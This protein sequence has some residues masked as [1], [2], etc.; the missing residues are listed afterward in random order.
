MSPETFG[1]YELLELLGRGGMG[2]VHRAWDTRRERVVAL[3][4][5]L[6][7]L[8]D[9]EQFR[10]RFYRECNGAAR[11]NE[12]H[13]VPIHDFGEIEGRLYLDMRLVD[14]R[15]LSELLEQ[16]GPFPADLAVTVVEQVA[17]ALDAAHA[18]GIIHRDVKP[19][20]VLVT[21]T[22]SVPHCYLV[23]F[24]IAGT[25]GGRTTGSLTRT[26]MFVGTLEYVA[27]ERLGNGPTDH[28]VDVYS[29]ACLL[30]QLLTG[31]P[32]FPTFDP[33]ALCAAH[34]YREPPRPSATVPSLP[35]ALDAVVARGM[36]KDPDARFPSAGA[37]AWAARAAL[38]GDDVRT[39][40]VPLR[41]APPTVTPPPLTPPAPATTG[42]HGAPASTPPV[43]AVTAAARSEGALPPTVTGTAPPSRD[44][45]PDPRQ[46]VGRRPARRRLAGALIAVAVAAAAAGGVVAARVLDG[47]STPV[48]TEAAD[49]PGDSPFHRPPGGG[50]QMGEQVPAP[51]QSS[52][53]TE[54]VSGDQPGLYGGT[55][56][57]VCDAAGL[58]RF[59]E[60]NPS[61]AAAWAEVQGI[62]PEGIGAFIADLTPVVL[63]FDT[64]VTNHGFV[65]GRATP[66][67]SVLQAGT[68]VLVDE[69]GSP[70]VR[71]ACGNPLDPPAPRPSPEYEGEPWP[72]FSE[73]VVVNVTPAPVVVN[74]LVV[75]YADG[76]IRERPLS[77]SGEEDKTPP[78]EVLMDAEEFVEDPTTATPPA[79]APASQSSPSTSPPASA[80]ASQ[81]SP[82]T[83][84]PASAPASQS[85]PSTSPP[86]DG[87]GG[88]G[89]G[90]TSNPDTG[91]TGTGETTNPDTGGTGTGE[92]TNPDT[93][94]TGT[95]ETTNPDTGGT[96]TGET[97]NPDTG[98]TGTGETTNPD[99]G[100][101]GT[102]E[103]T[104]PDTGG[105]GTGETTNPD[106]GGTGTGETTNPDTGGTGTGETTNPDTGGTGT[107]ETT[108]PDTGGTGTGETTNPDT[109]GTGTG[110]TTNPDTGGTG[111][112][113]TTN[114]DTGGT[115]TGE[116]T[117]PDTGGTET[118][119][120]TSGGNGED[121]S[122]GG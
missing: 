47:D 101:T 110:E 113:E 99:T 3:K 26:G 90:E 82:S 56:A 8:A 38:G 79:S 16:E 66:F 112:G 93:G 96:G 89:T 65:D 119:T 122:T 71:C 28:R 69:F 4:R 59:L 67:H 30:H 117:N 10:A 54:G 76:Q 116:T 40:V 62:E 120:D 39:P 83:S 102:G 23:D 103:T 15:D 60:A 108:N 52:A 51:E 21:G 86:D 111:T 44:E 104:N 94:G 13:V 85:S 80:P 100:G 78:P 72:S 75:V 12:A 2:E 42:G 9:D 7:E 33:A 35:P 97:T 25:T 77:T 36:A 32:P 109:G 91:G 121:T 43:P 31:Q 45:P 84:P 53:P 14:G 68:A 114:P 48:I 20:N 24:G 22:G 37:L 34:L 1:P 61:Q 19:S 115:G 95:G 17:A 73:D 58:T 88:T 41:G 64:A 11:L 63:R 70:Q 50:G 55:G 5:L 87:T 118:D 98:G 81:S 29:L 27:P 49:D 106:T 57:Q 46:P 74:A 6:P 105:T 18:A 107:G 92:T